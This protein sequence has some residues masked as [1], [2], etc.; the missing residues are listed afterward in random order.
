MSGRY[1]THWE[2]R[3]FVTQ[4]HRP[5]TLCK[6]SNPFSIIPTDLE[7]IRWV[8]CNADGYPLERILD[9]VQGRS[10]VN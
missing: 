7:S 4:T 1:S 2:K 10:A 8:N 5:S 9:K 3:R 6:P